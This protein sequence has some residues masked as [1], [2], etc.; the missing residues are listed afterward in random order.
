M[1]EQLILREAIP[2]DASKLLDFL[3]RASNQS[4]FIEHDF[5]ANVT[6]ESEEESLDE[7]YNSAEDELIVAIF[8]DDIIGFTRLEKTTDGIAEFGVV[9]DSDFWNNGIASYLIEEA[10]DWATDSTLNKLTL[11]VYKNNPAAIHIYEKYGFA[12]ES[13]T[14]KTIIMLKMV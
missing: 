13:E 3:K 11:E 12:T 6:V 14:D 5:L 8:D 4:N 2:S 7:I 1:S 10:L 9:V